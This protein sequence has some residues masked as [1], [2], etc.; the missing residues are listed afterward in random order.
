MQKRLQ[1]LLALF[2]SL[3]SVIC[4]S[5][6]DNQY[7]IDASAVM[8]TAQTPF[9]M[10]ANQFGKVPTEGQTLALFAS[11]K[12]DYQ[13]PENKIDW[14]YGINIGGFAGVQNKFIIQQAY[15]KAKWKAF[16]LYAGRREEIQGLVDTTLT[17]GSYIWSGNALPMPKIDLSIPN[18]TPIGSSG[19]FSIKGNYAHG[20]F[21]QNRADAIGIMLHQKSG[22]FRVGK[23][24]WK[25]KAYGGLIIRCSLVVKYNLMILMDII[26]RVVDLGHHLGTIFI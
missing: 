10:R 24:N 20:W 17:S 21:D 12:S 14:G 6:R 22:Y 5:Q 9:W 1:L 11:V 13:N 18:F 7:S 19:V 23:P 26:Q 8:G 2:F 15:L 25:F 16:E 4:F 3:H